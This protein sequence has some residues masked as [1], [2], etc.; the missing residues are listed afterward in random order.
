MDQFLKQCGFLQT[1]GDDENRKYYFMHLTFQEY[2]AAYWISHHMEKE[3]VVTELE[4]L[5]SDWKQFQIV[6]CFATA[7]CCNRLSCKSNHDSL[8]CKFGRN[9]GYNAATGYSP[10]ISNL[11]RGKMKDENHLTLDDITIRLFFEV[12]FTKLH[13]QYESFNYLSHFQVNEVK[14]KSTSKYTHYC[15]IQCLNICRIQKLD[16]Y[17]T[18]CDSNG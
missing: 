8:N 14:C 13:R 4:M 10:V 1:T 7:L 6:L 18:E 15:T 17:R 5:R 12:Y 16:M 3:I 11:I 2:F 9:F